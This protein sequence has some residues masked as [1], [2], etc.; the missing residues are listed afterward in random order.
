MF[1]FFVVVRVCVWWYG[2]EKCCK[3]SAVCSQASKR[4]DHS[5]FT[6]AGIRFILF[7]QTK[8]QHTLTSSFFFQSHAPILIQCDA[9]HDTYLSCSH[10]HCFTR[11]QNQWHVFP[12]PLQIVFYTITKLVKA[13]MTSKF[14]NWSFTSNKQNTQIKCCYFTIGV[15]SMGRVV[16]IWVCAAKS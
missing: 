4:E 6:K 15:G 14:E 2:V 1:V 10:P 7:K 5:S 3:S 13:W 16:N 12:C 11:Q 9:G 8:Y